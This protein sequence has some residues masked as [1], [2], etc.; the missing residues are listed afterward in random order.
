[1]GAL[2]LLYVNISIESTD[3]AQ[4]TKLIACKPTQSQSKNKADEVLTQNRAHSLCVF[5]DQIC[6]YLSARVHQHYTN[7]ALFCAASHSNKC[8]LFGSRRAP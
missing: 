8:T 6:L 4:T 7:Y 3:A 2:L 1:V 5:A